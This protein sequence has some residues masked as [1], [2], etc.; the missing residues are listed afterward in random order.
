MSLTKTKKK[1]HKTWGLVGKKN[2]KIK[3]ASYIMGRRRP[4]HDVARAEV[5]K[6][7]VAR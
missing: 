2:M 6:V 7:D 4:S 5:A 3:W 1:Q